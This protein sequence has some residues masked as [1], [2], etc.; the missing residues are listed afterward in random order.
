M[1]DRDLLLFCGSS[2]AVGGHGGSS[3]AA[4]PPRPGN[5]LARAL[6]RAGPSVGRSVPRVG[7]RKRVCSFTPVVGGKSGTLGLPLKVQAADPQGTI[8]DCLGGE[9]AVKSAEGLA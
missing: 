9:T 6:R 1:R 2:A 3:A 4:Q 5:K 8:H 7:L